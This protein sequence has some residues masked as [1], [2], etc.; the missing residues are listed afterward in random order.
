ML[1]RSLTLFEI[2]GIKVKVNLGWALIAAFIA[3]SLAQGVFPQL[4]EGLQPSAYRWMAVAA[5]FGLAASIVI[6][7]LAHS[8]VARAFGIPLEG[9]TLFALGGVAEIEEEPPSPT[10]EFLMAIAGP[11]TSVLLAVLLGVLDSAAGGPEA[12]PALSGVLNYLGLLNLVLAVFNMIPAFPLD[13]GRALRAI[14]WAVKK[15]YRAATRFAARLGSGFGVA[16]MLAGVLLALAGNFGAGLWWILIG[17]FLRGAAEGADFQEEASAQLKGRSVRAVMTADPDVVSPDLTI[18][19]F[20]E[21]HVY[22]LHHDLFPVVRDGRPVGVIGLREIKSVPRS[23]WD[24]V[25]VGQAAKP[26]SDDV[27]ID[28]S[29]DAFAA[30]ERMQRGRQSRLLVVD[31]GRLAGMLSLKDLLELIAVRLQL[32]NA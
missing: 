6:H 5:I 30:L 19:R 2:F 32:A 27:V 17:L 29:A 9:I 20:V 12:R 8:L 14:V 7:E 23:A 26:L 28:A 22:P 31:Q 16:L 1:G 21:D 10:A 15:D 3:W 11:A 24:S 18:A 13:G 4:Y 25:T